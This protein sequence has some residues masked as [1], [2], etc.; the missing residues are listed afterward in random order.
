MGCDISQAN[1]IIEKLGKHKTGKGCLYIN[2]LADIDKEVL[3]ELIK[4][5][6]KPENQKWANS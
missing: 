5:T 4:E 6:L 2:K 3:K 1:H